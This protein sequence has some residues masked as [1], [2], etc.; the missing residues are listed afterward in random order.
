MAIL[1]MSFFRILF[2]S[3]ILIS[4]FWYTMVIMTIS[5]SRLLFDSSK[6]LSL[7][8]YTMAILTISVFR[9]MESQKFTLLHEIDVLRSTPSTIKVRVLKVWSVKDNIK[10]NEDFLIEMVFMDESGKR[11]QSTVF[12]QDI[13]RF[14]R[15]LNQNATLT[16]VNPSLGS[17]A[18][19]YKVIDC[20][21]KLV[22]NSSTHVNPCSQFDGPTFG[23]KFY[24]F[25]S[26]IDKEISLKATIDIIGHV[27]HV[28][29]DNNSNLRDVKRNARLTMEISNISGDS[30]CVTLWGDCVSQFSKY[31]VDHF[32]ESHMII[33]MQFGR[34][35]YHKEKP[36]VS[37]SY[38]SDVTRVFLNDSISGLKII[39]HEFNVDGVVRRSI[40]VKLM[41]TL[42]EEFLMATS[43]FNICEICTILQLKSIIVLGTI[44]AVCPD[45][46]WYYVGCN[47]C[48]RKVIVTVV[49]GEDVYEYKN[50]RCNTL[51]VTPTPRFKIK[52]RVQNGSGVVSLTLFDRDA[53]LII[54]KTASELLAT[55]DEDDVGHSGFPTDLNCLLEK[56]FAFKVE[57]AD[58]NFRNNVEVYGISKLT[59]DQEII[60]AIEKRPM[61]EFIVP[62]DSGSLT[63]GN[64]L[65]DLQ[66]TSSASLKISEFG[67]NKTPVSYR[68]VDDEVNEIKMSSSDSDDKLKRKLVYVFEGDQPSGF[69]S[70]K[71]KISDV[72]DD[73]EL[74][75][76]VGSSK[77][78]VKFLTPKV[79]KLYAFKRPGFYPWP[80]LCCFV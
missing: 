72:Q 68:L 19:N 76:I 16:I 35:K 49:E 66:S 48:S 5:F 11:M 14:K 31:V 30:V 53:K 55:K 7:F 20:P 18:S 43:F 29:K 69:S 17:N 78:G 6:L 3:S 33:L 79:E 80:A 39:K 34:V 46:E 67:D 36:Y 9:S 70:T 25:K 45:S 42:D 60:S 50:Q 63:F 74:V 51:G 57:I 41:S 27:V 28:F 52:L 59:D 15:Y 21:N 44:K 8:R 71:S 4:L 61:P 37:N 77:D 12:K 58:F 65:T 24:S 47:S 75:S 38:G 1:T 73:S 26:V 2:D 64:S 40:P 10:P 56:K 23:F 54:N 32:D 62:S 13:F 22:L